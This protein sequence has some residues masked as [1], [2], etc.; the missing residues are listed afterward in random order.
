M[1]H[2]KLAVMVNNTFNSR[3]IEV[4]KK[5]RCL[6]LV[7]SAA[8]RHEDNSHI[9]LLNNMF[10]TSYS[11]RRLVFLEVSFSLAASEPN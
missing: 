3:I 6:C 8:G 1:L 9:A 4:Q 7:A 11:S 5:C 2:G 10:L